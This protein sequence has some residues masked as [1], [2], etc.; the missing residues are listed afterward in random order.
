MSVCLGNWEAAVTVSK[1]M[2][3]SLKSSTLETTETE[4]QLVLSCMVLL[5]QESSNKIQT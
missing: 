3:L 4:I 1:R 2:H 5:V